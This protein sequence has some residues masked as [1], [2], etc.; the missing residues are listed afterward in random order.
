M[1]FLEKRNIVIKDK[2]LLTRA[3]THSSYAFEHNVPSYERLEFLGDSV[4]QLIM[5]DYIY[6]NMDL[7]EGKMTK[8]R[9]SYVCESALYEYS[10]EIGL[11]K[12]IRFGNGQSKDTVSIV[13]DCFESVLAVIYLEHGM[14][15]ARKYVLDIITPYIDKG[16]TFIHDYKTYLQE[17]FQ[18][19]QKTITYVLTNVTEIGN[20]SR[21]F[22]MDVVID[23]IIYGHGS[24]KN[25]K[26][27]EQEA[28]KDA[29]SKMA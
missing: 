25:K 10:N 18:K 20:N 13:A 11:T 9:A 6:K 28:A 7:P 16:I 2:D 3:L 22:D 27:A 4:L 15:V 8:I 23:G 1:D 17:M 26:T 14:R 29:I 19:E 12:Y 5:S 21:I 24:G